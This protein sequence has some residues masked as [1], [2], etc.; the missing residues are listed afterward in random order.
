MHMKEAPKAEKSN[1]RYRNLLYDIRNH[2]VNAAIKAENLGVNN[3]SIILDPGL[4]GG[5][6]G[7]N[8]EQNF[9]I[10][11]NI[12][13]FRET[14]Y[15]ILAAPSKKS[16]IGDFLNKSCPEDRVWGTAAV[17]AWLT[18]LK[19]EIVRVHDV[20]EMVQVIQIY[21]KIMKEVV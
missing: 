16:F 18:G 2:L 5:C 11:A 14:G 8:T 17:I 9:Q 20:S 3:E 21:E 6:F 10:I 4:G 15:P 19:T 7:K 1:Y 12:N 13:F